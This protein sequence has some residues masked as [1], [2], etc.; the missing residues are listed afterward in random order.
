MDRHLKISPQRKVG[1]ERQ[2]SKENSC[3][4]PGLIDER[5]IRFIKRVGVYNVIQNTTAASETEPD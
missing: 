3:H 5:I 4:L 2:P 1:L